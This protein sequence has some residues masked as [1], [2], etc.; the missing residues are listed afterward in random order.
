MVVLVLVIFGLMIYQVVMQEQ[1]VDQYYF[2]VI[3]TAND[4]TSPAVLKF[5]NTQEGTMSGALKVVAENFSSFLGTTFKAPHWTDWSLNI[6]PALS[7]NQGGDIQNIYYH[8]SFP[9]T[10]TQFESANLSGRP[11]GIVYGDDSL[12]DVFSGSDLTTTIRWW[13]HLYSPSPSVTI[14]LFNSKR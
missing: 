10:R 11:I 6:I 2:N 14:F 8:F 1:K 12:S 9:I 5:P 4:A 3:L 7:T 13:S